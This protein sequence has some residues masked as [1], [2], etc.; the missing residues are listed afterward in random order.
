VLQSAIGFRYFVE[1]FKVQRIPIKG[2]PQVMEH[3][4]EVENVNLIERKAVLEMK[5]NSIY[6]LTASL[7]M[8]FLCHQA[9]YAIR[10]ER[11]KKSVHS[12]PSYTTRAGTKVK[13]SNNNTKTKSLSSVVRPVGAN[14]ARQCEMVDRPLPNCYSTLSQKVILD[15]DEPQR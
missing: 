9:L 1:V 4:G 3:D 15:R 6:F 5:R 12:R 8:M 11:T 7:L 2:H 10:T 13:I 14:L